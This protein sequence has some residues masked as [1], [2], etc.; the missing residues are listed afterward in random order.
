MRR[1][2]TAVAQQS[3]QRTGH[4]TRF[5]HCDGLLGMPDDD[6]P[7]WAVQ[8]VFHLR[9]SSFLAT[10]P[11]LV[12]FANQSAFYL[13]STE[14]LQRI[15]G[16]QS[17]KRSHKQGHKLSS[18]LN[19]IPYLW[20]NSMS[21]KNQL[22]EQLAV[23]STETLYYRIVEECACARL[24]PTFT[25]LELRHR[26]SLSR[27]LAPERG[28]DLGSPQPL[29]TGV[30]GLKGT[31]DLERHSYAGPKSRRGGRLVRGRGGLTEKAGSKT[32]RGSPKGD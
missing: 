22:V 26:V 31:E 13:A 16:V 20:D 5:L 24:L 21:V 6:M 2:W 17:T 28:F 15:I 11:S 29:E 25:A 3:F 9:A 12:V 27:P 18:N 4:R 30:D 23:T 8:H 1:A 32:L 10:P 14:D 19:K 7:L